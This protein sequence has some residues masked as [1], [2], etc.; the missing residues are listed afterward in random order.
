[1]NMLSF[2]KIGLFYLVQTMLVV[3]FV[4]PTHAVEPTSEE[5]LAA[6]KIQETYRAHLRN[7]AEKRFLKNYK[8]TLPGYRGSQTIENNLILNNPEEGQGLRNKEA[9]SKEK[10]DTQLEDMPNEI[11]V[12]IAKNLDDP[13]RRA[14]ACTSRSMKIIANDPFVKRAVIKNELNKYIQFLPIPE[15]TQA[16]VEHLQHAGVQTTITEPMEAYKISDVPV[17]IGLYRAI[18]GHYPDLEQVTYLTPEKRAE[19]LARWKANPDLPLTFTTLDQ[20]QAFVTRLR[21][22]TGR[23]LFIPDTRQVENA[24][25]GR[26]SENQITTT[27]FH[28]G[29]NENEVANRAFIYSNSGNQA[30]GVHEAL[31]GP[32]KTIED[33]KNSYGLIH[34]IGNVWVRSSEG[35]IRGGA[36]YDPWLAESSLRGE[37]F[38]E[39]RYDNIGLRLA[40]VP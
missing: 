27:R 13:A 33:S 8:A 20:D 10:F 15:V 29:D 1:M 40:E 24:I 2:K 37:G 25:R 28:F 26:N 34:P 9:A 4:A 36:F 16:D 17:T 6:K 23:N 32:G 39:S 5:V 30:H 3:L 22:L 14:F 12:E 31:P 21:E 35:D 38:A 7:K 11:L 18:M 19:I